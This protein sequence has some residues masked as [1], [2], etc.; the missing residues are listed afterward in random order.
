VNPFPLDGTLFAYWF[1][2]YYMGLAIGNQKIKYELKVGKIIFLYVVC[3]ILSSAEAF[4][5][6]QVCNYDMATTQLRFGS[7]LTNIPFL[8]IADQYIRESKF[9]DTIITKGMIFLGNQSFGIYLSHVLIISVL[10]KLPRYG[11][12]LY[13]LTTIIVILL[14]S[15]CSYAGYKILAKKSWIL[16]L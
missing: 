1:L 9:R 7:M 14:S 6:N 13:P 15:F 16:G 12:L 5:W 8:L 4:L 3:L 11:D 10:E 2:Y